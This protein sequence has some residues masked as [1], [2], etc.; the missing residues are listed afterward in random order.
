MDR[1]DLMRWV[2]ALPPMAGQGGMETAILRWARTFV[3]AGETV[4]WITWPAYNK[5][6]SAWYSSLPGHHHRMPTGSFHH[7]TWSEI[8]F[9]ASV[10]DQERPDVLVVPVGS[11]CRRIA[12]ARLALLRTQIPL[13]AW[14][15][16][17]PSRSV[18]PANRIDLDLADGIWA[19]GRWV[20]ADCVSQRP[21]V[22]VVPN[23]QLDAPSLQIEPGQDPTVAYVGRWNADQK[24]LD[25]LLSAWMPLAAKIRLVLM[26][27]PVYA[28]QGEWDRVYRLVNE[29]A[30]S[31]RL[32]VV[33]WTEDPWTRL[34]AM[35]VDYLVLP[36]DDEGEPLVA[37]E[38]LAWGLPI[39]AHAEATELVADGRNGYVFREWHEL[40]DLL[41]LVADRQLPRPTIRLD[42][43]QRTGDHVLAVCHASV[44]TLRGQYGRALSS[45]SAQSDRA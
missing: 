13:V 21:P 26:G 9:I 43:G 22:W 45:S 40:R 34:A 14:L 37:F 12:V 27:E 1:G 19:C 42:R 28:R 20:A 23:I 33:P 38:A 18:R 16:G 44:Q 36:H 5:A 11:D 31:P 15:H 41:A 30:T 25:L 24:G 17:K 8:A 10:V 29:A 35:G 7:P 4:C 6:A 32:Q 3:D 2:V 39:L